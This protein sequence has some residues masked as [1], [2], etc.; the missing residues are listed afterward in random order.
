M[1]TLKVNNIADLG[2]D[3]VLTNGVL[4]VTPP[5]ILQVVKASDT[6][7]RTTNTTSFTDVTGMSVSITPTATSSSIIL[8]ASFLSQNAQGTDN[9]LVG[10][11]QIA[12]SSNTAIPGTE[13]LPIGLLRYSYTPDPGQVFLPMTL[14]SYDSPST[15]SE[16]TYKLRFRSVVSQN[17]F[18]V[19]NARST[20]HLFA[21]EVAG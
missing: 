8:I 12:D 14:V 1:S 13:D 18:S 7:Q 6:T 9:S 3:P 2:N 15:T 20:G 11:A 17:T 16:K 21:I 19:E 5:A 4:D 10:Y